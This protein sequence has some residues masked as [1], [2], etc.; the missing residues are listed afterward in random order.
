MPFI[1]YGTRTFTVHSRHDRYTAVAV[2]AQQTTNVPEAT[3]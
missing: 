2:M 3:L 1:S